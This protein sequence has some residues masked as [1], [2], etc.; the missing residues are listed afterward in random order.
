MDLVYFLLDVLAGQYDEDPPNRCMQGMCHLLIFHA[1][2]RLK[3]EMLLMTG[4][5]QSDSALPIS[6]KPE[7]L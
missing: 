2:L 5:Q 6:N 4:V 7:S 1:S 3:H